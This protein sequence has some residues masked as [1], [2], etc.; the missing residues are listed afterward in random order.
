MK[1]TRYYAA[2]ITAFTIWGFFSLALKPL[3]VYPSLDI[4]F[5]RVFSSAVIM[6][7]AAVLLRRKAAR[8]AGK[9]YAALPP[10]QKRGLVL[11]VLGG[12]LFLM[13]NWFFFIYVTNQ[14]S[15]KAAAFA[16]FVCPI[17]T[18][19]LACFFLKEQLNRMQWMAV[20]LSGIGCGLLAF[21][22]LMNLVYSLVIALSYALYLVSQR[23]D[24]GV[25]RFLVLTLE[26]VL[27][28]LILLPFYPAAAGKAPRV[29]SF[30]GPISFIA[31]FFTIIPLYLNLYAL[32]GLRSSTVG[33]LLYITPLLGV[34]IAVM[35]YSEK[36]DTLQ[37]I[38]YG[39][40]F[41]SVILFHVRLKGSVLTSS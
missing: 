39:A 17:L 1:N 28:A 40:I 29:F 30:Y 9:R 22:S 15:V 33:I 35:I 7:V 31:V 13:G 6:L 14:I 41:F 8:D 36:L 19:V 12:G 10:D 4:L 3:S 27:A 18:A 24:Y 34:I 25:D 16:Y 5:Y 37:Y 38:A 2:A 20:L 26:V 21:N 32:K 23:K 11:Q